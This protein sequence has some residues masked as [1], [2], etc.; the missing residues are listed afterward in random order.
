MFIILIL[1]VVFYS[2]VYTDERLTVQR[3]GYGVNFDKVGSVLDTGGV[4]YYSHTWAIRIPRFVSEQVQLFNCDAFT[5]FASLCCTMNELITASNL[6]VYDQITL[7]EG[8]ILRVLNTVDTISSVS[9]HNDTTNEPA[10][11]PRKRRSAT[12][13]L[14]GDRRWEVEERIE[15]ITQYLPVS[16]SAQVASDLFHIPGPRTLRNLKENIK[17]MGSLIYSQRTEYLRYGKHLT[18]MI[19][20]INKRVDALTD[21]GTILVEKIKQVRENILTHHRQFL[22]AKDDLQN[23]L[24]I[25]QS[26]VATFLM[27]LTPSL[28]ALRSNSDNLYDFGRMWS[29][30][31]IQLSTGYLSETL[32]TPEM[33]EEVLGYITE[34]VLKRPGYDDFGLVNSS[35]LFYYKIKKIT[36]T[37]SDTHLFV[38]LGFPLY[39][40]G[41]A[42]PLYR[43]DVFPVPVLSGI[44]RNEAQDS[45]DGYTLVLDLPDFIAV[46]DTAAF[47]LEMNTA[48]Y[49][50][51]EGGVESIKI[52]GR[53]MEALKSHTSSVT[54]C[55]YAIFTDN[56][57]GVEANCD[58]G[59]TKLA[60]R[61]G[62]VQLASDNT[63]LVHRGSDNNNWVLSCPMSSESPSSLI[64]PCDMCRLTI[65]CGCSL[66]AGHFFIPQRLTGCNE[67][68]TA[69]PKTT[70][71]YHRNMVTVKN[72]VSKKDLE[73]AHSFDRLIDTYFPPFKVPHIEFSTPD[74]VSKYVEISDKYAVDYKKAAALSKKEVEIFSSNVDEGLAKVKNFSDQIVD[75]TSRWDKALSDL[76]TGIFGNDVWIVIT[77]ICG[78]AGLSIVAF[79]ISAVLFFPEF[80][81]FLLEYLSKRRE[82][83]ADN[84]QLAT[85]LSNVKANPQYQLSPHY[86][87]IRKYTWSEGY[88]RW[89]RSI[90]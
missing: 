60:P 26:L 62:A 25:I 14:Y 13:A 41:G 89:E 44:N 32:V 35:P 38:T 47:Y 40:I 42:T 1:F 43:I 6:A 2:G 15:A 27:K 28:V 71:I 50:S 19:S 67:T 87:G 17:A 37:R 73:G 78:P 86:Y 49:M 53:G 70:K 63:F 72:F 76:V 31:V 65:P 29:Q 39:K 24:S 48:T 81:V 10:R 51:C 79:I 30:G 75:R 12:E 52:C 33:I 34:N 69:I 46:S 3:P 36:Y 22:D 90:S 58:I 64:T 16:V 56:H 82:R 45:D 88:H 66:T 84:K 59:Y 20:T 68:I 5:E 61:G 57:A 11:S 7:A 18:G 21:E 80:T 23:K 85:I 8:L 55:A 74:Q 77:F 83:K 4:A 9:H 54:S